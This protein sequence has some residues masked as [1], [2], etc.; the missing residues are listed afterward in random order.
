MKSLAH[1][2]TGDDDLERAQRWRDT[3]SLGERLE[4]CIRWSAV[5]RADEIARLG[6]EEARRR[7]EAREPIDLT[8]IWKNLHPDEG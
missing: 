8:A 4:E 5:L 3:R 2:D 6:P 1:L 7:D